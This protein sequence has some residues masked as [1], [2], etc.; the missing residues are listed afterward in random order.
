ME[1][2]LFRGF[3]KAATLLAALVFLVACSPKLDWRT[4]QSP[5]ERYTALFTGKPEKLER[6]IPYEG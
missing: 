4:V 6:K 3:S 5:Q 2:G 1:P